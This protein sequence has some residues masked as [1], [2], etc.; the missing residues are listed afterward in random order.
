MFHIMPHTKAQSHD[1]SSQQAS[2]HASQ[3]SSQQSSQ[4]QGERYL[5][6]GVVP[7]RPEWVRP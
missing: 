4:R 6:M 7:Q 3:Q 1:W 5:T 2:Q